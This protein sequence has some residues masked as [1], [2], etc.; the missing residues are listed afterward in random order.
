MMISTTY[1]NMVWDSGAYSLKK[2]LVQFGPYTSIRLCLKKL[3]L[4]NIEN[5]DQSYKLPVGY[6]ATK[7]IFLNMLHTIDAFQCIK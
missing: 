1:C 7:E 3:S 2:I 4:L 5:T 6:L